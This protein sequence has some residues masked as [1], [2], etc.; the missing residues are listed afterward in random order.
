MLRPFSRSCELSQTPLP[1]S[2]RRSRWSASRHQGCPW[3][4][5]LRPPVCAS[6]ALTA[7][8]SP[9]LGPEV[10]SSGTVGRVPV[11][12][13]LLPLLFDCLPAPPVNF[14][15]GGNRWSEASV[16]SAEKLTPATC[17]FGER[18]RRQS[19]C[20]AMSVIGV[21]QAASA[22]VSLPVPRWKKLTGDAAQ[23]QLSRATT[24]AGTT[25]PARRVLL[26]G[27]RYSMGEAG[28]EGVMEGPH[29]R[30]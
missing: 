23:P 28:Y 3:P 14:S 15:H 9:P 22:R 20:A 6:F 7:H 1:A 12:G 25:P 10:S 5:L 13:S 30:T 29:G 2:C 8:R 26:R 11:P 27:W 4:E 17:S 24:R 19:N 18:P 21:S 16:N